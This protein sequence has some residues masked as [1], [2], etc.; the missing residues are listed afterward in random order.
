M[1]IGIPYA[2]ETPMTLSTRILS[3]LS[4]VYPEGLSIAH[5]KHNRILALCGFNRNRYAV[6]GEVVLTCRACGLQTAVAYYLTLLWGKAPI[7]SNCIMN[8]RVLHRGVAK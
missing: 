5:G 3:E 1:W 6:E 4:A 2:I 7:C 8:S